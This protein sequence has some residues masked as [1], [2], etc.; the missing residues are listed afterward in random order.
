[1]ANRR[2]N[3]EPRRPGRPARGDQLPD[4]TK[5]LDAAEI[6]IGREGSAV[7]LDAIAR[8]AGITKPV[9][10]A[11]V[12]GRDEMANALAERLTDRLV[13]A[14]G[15]AVRGQPFGRE[16]IASFVAANLRV[17]RDHRELFLYVTGGGA[18]DDAAMRSIHLARLSVA[19]MSNFLA[20]AREL[21]GRDPSV[22]DAWAWAIV[23][24]LNFISLRLVSDEVA[25]IE[26]LADQVSS[27]LWSGLCNA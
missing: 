5:V 9:I 27:L 3:I 2:H 1:M 13:K 20:R 7:S 21:Q 8:E 14:G 4:R 23:G 15:D 18:S 22:A 12:G 24:M 16:L 17:V 26:V 6:A 11:R 10:Y 25:D 19:P